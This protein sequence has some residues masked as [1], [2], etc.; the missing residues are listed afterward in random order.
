MVLIKKGEEFF[1]KKDYDNALNYYNQAKKSAKSQ[2]ERKHNSL[3]I[4]ECCFETKDL[5]K[6]LDEFTYV[7]IL[8][9]KSA[10]ENEDKKYFEFFKENALNGKKRK[11]LFDYMSSFTFNPNLDAFKRIFEICEIDATYKK[12]NAF[13]YA[14]IK[15]NLKFLVENGLDPNKDCGEG[16]PAIVYHINSHSSCILYLKEQ[17]ADLDLAMEYAKRKNN[18]AGMCNLMECGAKK[19]NNLEYAMRY[20]QK[21]NYFVLIERLLDM[22]AKPGYINIT[23]VLEKSNN[24]DIIVVSKLSKIKFSNGLKI[25]TPRMKRAVKSIGERFEFYRS[26]FN[27]ELVDEASAA[28]DDLYKIYKVKPVPRR[29]I[30]D[31]KKI[32]VKSKTWQEQHE[33]LWQM[34]VP[35]SGAASSVQGELIRI[36]GRAT[37]EIY[38]NGGVNWENEYPKMMDAI[39]EYIKMGKFDKNDEIIK[40]SK[41]INANSDMDDLYLLSQLI[42]EWVLANPEIIEL[43]NVDYKI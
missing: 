14:N 19:E 21:H 2:D 9:G 26:S 33:E 41:K 11:H 42:V 32:I 25:I 10:F 43:K 3:R 24:G 28:L 18:I 20:A 40:L 8:G 30:E 36:V 35:G 34:L 1:E 15:D 4:G 16:Y 22:G 37:D 5:K 6:A 13:A 29:N 27:E 39:P 31:I 23:K 17:G 7:Y 12:L 38:R